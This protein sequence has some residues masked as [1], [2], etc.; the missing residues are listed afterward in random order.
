ML[1]LWLRA[2]RHGH[3]FLTDDQIKH[4]YDLTRDVYIPAAEIWVAEQGGRIIGFVALLDFLIGGLF[5]DPA[6]HGGGIGR[7]LI[8]QCRTLRPS[9][10][11]GV[12]ALNQAAVGFYR[13][14]GFTEVG[15]YAQDDAGLPFEVIAMTL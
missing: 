9:L 15:R 5:V 6:H 11:L 7:A 8:T 13:H 1:D 10:T 3:P 4:Q 12:Y 14:L 2:S